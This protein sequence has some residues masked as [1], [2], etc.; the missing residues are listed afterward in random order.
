MTQRTQWPSARFNI[1][2][3]LRNIWSWS[4]FYIYKK[5]NFSVL[6]AFKSERYS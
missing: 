4:K 3:N 1:V 5:Q 6:R 2:N